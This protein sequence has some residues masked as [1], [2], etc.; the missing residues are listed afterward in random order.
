MNKRVA[1]FVVATAKYIKFLKPLVT[2][3]NQHFLK[4]ECDVDVIIFTD[5]EPASSIT[6]LDDWESDRVQLV[7]MH[8][9]HLPWPG[10]TLKR[11]EIFLKARDMF[12]DYTHLFYCDVDMLFVDTVGSEVLVEEGLVAT[13]HP[14]FYNKPRSQFTYETNIHSVAYIPEHK[15]LFYFAGGFQGGKS[16]A[17]E[18]AI[19]KLCLKI[20]T[21]EERGITAVWHDESH[22]NRYLID[23]HPTRVLSPSYC[24]PEAWEW[25][26]FPRR[27]LALDKDHKEMRSA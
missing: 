10:P 7:W 1:L 15:G 3:V 11:Y 16:S 22:W 6:G 17:Y 2:S 9:E 8:Q 23:N 13:A 19:V 4:D 21:D 18:Q 12:P 26:P 14:G 27:L 25:L 5:H 24:F 20:N